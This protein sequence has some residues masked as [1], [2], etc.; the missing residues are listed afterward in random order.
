MPRT[1]LAEAEY[2]DEAS[3]ICPNPGFEPSGPL[4]LPGSMSV[5]DRSRSPRFSDDEVRQIL[6]RAAELD[7]MPTGTS[8]RDLMS[9]AQEAGMKEASVLQAAAEIVDARESAAPPVPTSRM[10]FWRFAALKAAGVG[11]SLG[12]FTGM[13]ERFVANSGL[14]DVPS[15]AALV[16]F[17]WL[18]CE[19]NPDQ[20]RFPLKELGALLVSYGAGWVFFNRAVPFEFVFA[21]LVCGALSMVIAEVRRFVTR[22]FKGRGVPEG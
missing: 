9:S 18:L 20:A 13:L 1:S 2:I 22:I 14:V 3:S 16:G 5:D 21:L 12:F 8:L 4:P 11:V 7:E 19:A 15:A 6:R 10:R 17:G